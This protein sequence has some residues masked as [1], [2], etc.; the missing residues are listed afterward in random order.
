MEGGKLQGLPY[1]LPDAL[2]VSEGTFLAVCRGAPG[3]GSTSEIQE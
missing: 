3:N 1:D 2:S